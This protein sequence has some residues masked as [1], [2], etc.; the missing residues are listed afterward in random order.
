MS[1]ALDLKAIAAASTHELK[2]LLGQLT[3]ALDR[4]TQIGCPGGEEP[5]ASA[6][7]ACRR[8][9]DRLVEMLTLYKFEDRAFRPHV[10]AHS[11]ADFLDD[12]ANEA[13]ALAGHQLAIEVNG[14]LAP[15]YWFFDRGLVESA[16]M[17]ALHN[18]FAYARTRITLTATA[19]DGQLAFR[20]ADDGPGFPPEALAAA[21]D[22]PRQSTRGTGLGLYFA[23]RVASAHENKNKIGR[24]R[25]NNEGGGVFTLL[26]P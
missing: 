11:P 12:L 18:A 3:L 1:D 5:L 23:Q 7:F 8:I 2:N 21:L 19:E 17:N 25:L 22:G 24:V 14:A 10:D 20:I 15:P 9:N 13:R 6:R 4:L 16:L 26:L